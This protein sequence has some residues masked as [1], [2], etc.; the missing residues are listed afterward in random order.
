MRSFVSFPLERFGVFSRFSQAS[1][2]LAKFFTLA[3]T[4]APNTRALMQSW[5]MFPSTCAV[6]PSSAVW[7][8]SMT[9]LSMRK[10][11]V[12]W[13]NEGTSCPLSRSSDLQLSCVTRVDLQG[14]SLLQRPS[15][16]VAR[17]SQ[18][19]RATLLHFGTSH[20]RSLSSQR[21]TDSM[22]VCSTLKDQAITRNKLSCP[23][24]CKR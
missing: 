19:M 14:A 5:K 13:N 18:H 3:S 7:R 23:T 15:V 20:T 8:E 2:S 11:L 10:L 12:Y 1:R 9:M 16:P 21:T 22:P 17:Q 6:I 4:V 24:S